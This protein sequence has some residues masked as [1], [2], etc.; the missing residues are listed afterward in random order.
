MS[1]EKQKYFANPKIYKWSDQK[2]TWVRVKNIYICPVIEKKSVYPQL[3]AK[4]TSWWW[5]QTRKNPVDT[6]V[7]RFSIFSI[8]IYHTSFLSFCHF[9]NKCPFFRIFWFFVLQKVDSNQSENTKLGSLF[10]NQRFSK[11]YKMLSFAPN[12]SLRIIP[13]HF[14]S[15]VLVGWNPFNLPEVR[16]IT[17]G[18]FPI[19]DCGWQLLWFK[20]ADPGGVPGINGLPRN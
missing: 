16:S 11:L 20:A 18:H 3:V 12:W 1:H 14:Y 9:Q 7:T 15:W 2:K 4:T 13:G 8:N 10:C 17:N 6:T 19:C 5:L